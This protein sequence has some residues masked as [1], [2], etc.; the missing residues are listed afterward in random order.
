MY[1]SLQHP[2]RY[3]YYYLKDSTFAMYWSDAKMQQ[4][5]T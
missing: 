3:Y 1:N 2:L 4:E 5:V